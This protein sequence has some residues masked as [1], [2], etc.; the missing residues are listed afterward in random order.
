M[1]ECV[2]NNEAVI[3]FSTDCIVDLAMNIRSDV[4]GERGDKDENMAMK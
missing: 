2:D 4:I 1:T 3:T